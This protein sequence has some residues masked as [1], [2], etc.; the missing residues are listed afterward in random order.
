MNHYQVLGVPPTSTIRTIRKTYYALAKRYHP[1][2]QSGE[3]EGCEAFKLISEAYSTLSN[4]KK[5]YLYDIQLEL[6]HDPV[7][8]PFHFTDE[9]LDLLYSYYQRITRSTEVRFLG[10]LYQSLPPESRSHLQDTLKAHLKRIRVLFTHRD[11]DATESAL[12]SQEHVRT[13]DGRGLEEDF[14]IHLQRDFHEVYV[15][16]CKE[17]QVILHDHTHHLFI[18]HSD[19][20]MIF[21]NGEHRLTLQIHTKPDPTY[22]LNGYDIHCEIPVN[23][24]QYFFE[25]RLMIPCPGFKYSHDPQVTDIIPLQHK[26]LHDPHHQVRGTLYLHP[27][28]CYYM[29]LGIAQLHKEFLYHLLTPI[30][31]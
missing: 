4:P 25:N 6:A 2:K 3:D 20:E 29:N 10:L 24:Y 17:I 31:M 7:S 1:D 15:N 16:Q 22:T 27:T 9:E 5:R 8:D 12:L 26:G 14:Q 11:S 13:I 28:I 23:L 18:T 21:R 30:A 19:Y